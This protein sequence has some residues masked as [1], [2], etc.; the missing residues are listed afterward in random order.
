VHA[1]RAHHQHAFGTQV[2]GR[3]DGGRLAH[4]AVAEV[5]DVAFD[6]DRRGREHE[7]NGRR[8]QQV[9]VR[10]AVAH[11]A[12]LRAHPGVLALARFEEGHVLARAVARCRDRQR[13]QVALADQARQA[14]QRHHL[15]EQVR[16]RIVVQ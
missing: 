15:D 6:V 1:A 13:L 11:G 5:F 10:D 3:G 8:S 4:G 7:G 12:A 2:D 14:H 16:Q 9:L